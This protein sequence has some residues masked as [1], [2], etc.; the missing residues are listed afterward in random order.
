MMKRILIADDEAP[1]LLMIKTALKPIAEVEILQ[2]SDGEQALMMARTHVP[3]LMLLDWMMPKM[4]GVE[5][6]AV[7]RE[8]PNL[9]RALELLAARIAT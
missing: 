3:D 5:V 9:P 1:L 8:K 7:L 2:A 4:T 6:A